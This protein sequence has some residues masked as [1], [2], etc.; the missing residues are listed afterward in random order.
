F[1]VHWPSRRIR[2]FKR[3]MK[4]RV[5]LFGLLLLCG[6]HVAAQ[7]RPHAFTGAQILPISGEPISNGVL[8]VHRGKITAVGA[9][10]RVN[11]PSDAV[12]VDATGKIIMPGLVDT[13][14]HIGGGDG[15]DRSSPT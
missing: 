13:H 3:H 12:T 9:V 11:I 6:A 2:K 7:E 10:G 8:V 14:S 5:S 4:T 15:G 1:L